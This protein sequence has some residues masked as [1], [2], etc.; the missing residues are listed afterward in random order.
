MA[1]SRT[2]QGVKERATGEF[3]KREKK[4]AKLVLEHFNNYWKRKF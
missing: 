4:D 3:D 2:T 1:D